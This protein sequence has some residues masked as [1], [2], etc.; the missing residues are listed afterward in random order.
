M[1]LVIPVFLDH[2]H[3]G[4]LVHKSRD[5][6]NVAV[7]I[8]PDNAVSKPENMIDPII[9]DKILLDLVLIQMWVPVFGTFERFYR[10]SSLGFA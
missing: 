3:H 2:R 4:I 7:G 8:I 5:I 9:S 10:G 1:I 6:I